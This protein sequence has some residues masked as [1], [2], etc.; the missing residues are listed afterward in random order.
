MFFQEFVATCPTPPA[1]LNAALL[2]EGIIGGLDVSRQ[3]PNGMLFCVTE[4][5]SRQEIDRLVAALGRVA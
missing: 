2:E 4:M 1:A 5:N 3:V